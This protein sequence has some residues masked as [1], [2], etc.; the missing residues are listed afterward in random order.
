[1]LLSR[2]IPFFCIGNIKGP[3]DADF[4]AYVIGDIV[5]KKIPF[6]DLPFTGQINVVKLGEDSTS[7]CKN[8]KRKSTA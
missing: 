6:I 4:V 5:L 1:M 3:R 7:A 8:S 2:T